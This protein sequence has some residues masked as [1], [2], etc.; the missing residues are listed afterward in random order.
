MLGEDIGRTRDVS[1]AMKMWQPEQC[2]RSIKPLA[3]YKWGN[4]QDSSVENIICHCQ[5]CIV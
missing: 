4:L 3:E 1:S 5:V 2:C